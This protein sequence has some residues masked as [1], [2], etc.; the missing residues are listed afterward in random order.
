MPIALDIQKLSVSP[1][2][3]LF[4]LTKF[5]LSDP[6]EVFRFC[7]L[8]T[9]AWQGNQYVGVPCSGSDFS[10]SSQ[11]FPRP[12]LA[13]GNFE[14]P[15]TGLRITAL[16]QQFN[17]FIGATVIRHTTLEKYLDGL[18]TANPLEEFETSYWRVEQKLNDDEE[19]LQWE[20]S[21][22]GL[23]DVELPRR[24]FFSNYCSWEYRGD[25]CGYVGGAIAKIDNTAT[26]DLA[27]DRCGKNR[28]ACALR[29]GTGVRRFGGF[30]GARFS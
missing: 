8:G 6:S 16:S 2:V 27:L 30:P 29:F 3:E 10:L 23:E 5:N 14:I 28:A 11:S 17:D 20:L 25:R 7:S 24:R 4:E 18:P 9:V 13:I 15:S 26:S 22:L 19:S 1:E 12:K 21:F